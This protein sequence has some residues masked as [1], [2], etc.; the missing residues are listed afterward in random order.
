MPILME[1]T[2][3]NEHVNTHLQVNCCL[4]V[5]YGKM[6]AFSFILR[7]TFRNHFGL[8]FIYV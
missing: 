8:N 7:I 3:T 6:L 4:V 2:N 1:T 5:P